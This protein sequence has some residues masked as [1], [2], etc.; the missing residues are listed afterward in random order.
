MA[1]VS[2]RACQLCGGAGWQYVGEFGDKSICWLCVGSGGVDEEGRP[3]AD[4]LPNVD[5]YW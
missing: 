5:P 3:L 1:A 2:A 4:W